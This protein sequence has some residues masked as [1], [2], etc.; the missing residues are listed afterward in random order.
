MDDL[1]AQLDR[2]EDAQL[3]YVFERAKHTSD[4]AG[5]NQA[6]ISKST[7]YGWSAEQRAHLNDLAQQLKRRAKLR[8]Q[9]AYEE[10]AEDAART[11]IDLMRHDNENVALKAA[12]DVL[13]RTTGKPRAAVD[14]TSGGA[15]LKGYFGV[16]PDDWDDSADD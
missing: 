7:F 15:Q 16:S 2:L 13:D 9:L 4:A 5:Y 11:I 1:R 12:Q 10:A 14:V 8:V 3:E 6:G